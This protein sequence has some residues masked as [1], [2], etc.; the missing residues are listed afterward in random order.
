MRDDRL[1]DRLDGE[2]LPVRLIC[3]MMSTSNG[4]SVPVVAEL[5]RQFA[6]RYSE[7]PKAMGPAK[8]FVLASGL[9]RPEMSVW[10]LCVCMKP[11]L[12][13]ALFPNP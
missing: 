8:T 11:K 7:H 2:T 13:T 5:V 12:A 4:H 3:G 9:R 6:D 10:L 1:Q